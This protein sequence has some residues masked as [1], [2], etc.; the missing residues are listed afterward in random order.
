VQIFRR[1]DT[2]IP[3]TTLSHVLASSPPPPSL[4]KLAD[5]RSPNAQQ[6][7]APRLV[8]PAPLVKPPTSTTNTSQRGWTAVVAQSGAGSGPRSR[9][10]TP[11]LAIPLPVAVVADTTVPDNWEDDE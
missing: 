10:Q 6:Q 4:G 11:S 7:R 8:A 3:V 9:T 5:L 1:I 2:R